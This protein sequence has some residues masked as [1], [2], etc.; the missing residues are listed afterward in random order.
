MA[1]ECQAGVL[2]ND[3]WFR[4]QKAVCQMQSTC[5]SSLDVFPYLD[6]CHHPNCVKKFDIPW[7][8][9]TSYFF[10]SLHKKLVKCAIFRRH[11]IHHHICWLIDEWDNKIYVWP[12]IAQ[13]FISIHLIHCLLNVTVTVRLFIFSKGNSEK[14]F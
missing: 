9:R 12:D 13:E 7:G 14:R 10:L 3:S 4:S 11:I 2:C 5:S 8:Q 1:V 6:Q